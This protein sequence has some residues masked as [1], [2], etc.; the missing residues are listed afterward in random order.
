VIEPV[1]LPP[2]LSPHICQRALDA[3]DPRFDGLFFVG[4]VTTRIYC[5]PT[6]PSRRADP[7]NR[8]FYTSAAAAESAGFRP[9]LRCRPELAPGRAMMDAVS[10][11]AYKA[12]HRISAGALNGR[13]VAALAA[14]LGVS[15]R[16]LRRALRREIGVSPLELAQTHRLLLAKRLLAD[17]V[18]PVTDIA[19]ASG[20]ESLRRFNVAFRERYGMSPS[21]LR[22]PSAARAARRGGPAPT[23]AG[24]LLRMTLAYRPPLAWEV[25]LAFLWSAAT[26]GVEI[27]DGRRYGR[28]LRLDG[29]SGV[30][31]VEEAPVEAQLKVALSPSLLP[32][33][34]PL[35]ARLRHFFDLDAQP[36]M[37]DAH[38]ER[39]GLAALVRRRRGVRLPGALD[40]FEVALRTLLR[41]RTAS[42]AATREL[43]GRVARAL[44]EPLETGIPGLDRLAPTA[45]RVA[46]AGAAGLLAAGVPRRRAEAIL[47]LA[48]AVAGGTLG[49]EPG[50][51]VAE[52][53]RALRETTGIDERLATTIVMRALYWPDAFPATDPAL[54]RA[55]GAASPRSL[56]ARAE[57]WRPW[58]AYA[59][60]HLWLEPGEG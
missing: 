3:R 8:R 1:Q 16:H 33:L 4:I 37:V 55:A 31:L 44:G 46:D 43:A 9:C 52:T 53:Q 28:T 51:D 6:C 47:A 34:M 42:E 21:A 7:D 41:G 36:T 29:R 24:E 50:N 39:G 17:T 23:T 5:R 22:R 59:A 2:S 54:Q 40:G 14:E 13:S 10:R 58:R 27:V 48:R 45:D 12:A 49:L 32:V 30:V 56:L 20:F 38:L 60:L 57:P 11:L 15:E 19:F 18:L 25:L 35:L 26:P